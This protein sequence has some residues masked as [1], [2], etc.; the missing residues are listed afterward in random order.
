MNARNITA[1]MNLAHQIGKVDAIADLIIVK[2]RKLEAQ[3]AVLLTAARDLDAAYRARF[4]VEGRGLVGPIDENVKALAEAIR[5][6][7]Q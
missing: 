2:V 6:A 1:A 5:S 3:K 4:D 7:E